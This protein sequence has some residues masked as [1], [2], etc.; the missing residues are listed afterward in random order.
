MKLIYITADADDYRFGYYCI[1]I[2]IFILTHQKAI[3]QQ[4]Y[5]D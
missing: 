2:N 4:V 1:D 3:C 5:G